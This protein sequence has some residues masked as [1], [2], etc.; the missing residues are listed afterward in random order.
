MK[1]KFKTRLREPDAVREIHQIRARILRKARKVG[2]ANYYLS[3]NQR[4]DL[5]IRPVEA[6]NQMLEE[7]SAPYRAKLPEP[8]AL[9][10]VHKWR[11]Q[12]KADMDRLGLDAYLRH[13]N[14]RTEGLL[15]KSK[16]TAT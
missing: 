8:V 16:K 14:E 1:T 7:S 10:E 9:R 15:R 5:L 11:R 3:L 4:P 2:I 6:K 13:L 12:I